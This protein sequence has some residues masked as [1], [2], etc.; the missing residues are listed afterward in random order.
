MRDLKTDPPTGDDYVM[1]LPSVGEVGTMYAASNPNPEYAQETDLLKGYTHWM[2]TPSTKTTTGL[3]AYL[4][5]LFWK[6]SAN[7]RYS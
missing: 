6:F 4:S 3:P 5:G 7:S 2:P 1:L